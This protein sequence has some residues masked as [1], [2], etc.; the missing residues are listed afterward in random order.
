VNKSHVE[1]CWAGGYRSERDWSGGGCIRNWLQLNL[2]I[3]K[4]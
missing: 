4:V 1:A 2:S 3:L